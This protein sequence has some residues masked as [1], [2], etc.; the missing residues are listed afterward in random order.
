MS[1][2]MYASGYAV[3]TDMSLNAYQLIYARH[4][5]MAWRGVVY[6]SHMDVLRPSDSA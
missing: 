5:A 4:L 6:G 3:D 1:R 2:L